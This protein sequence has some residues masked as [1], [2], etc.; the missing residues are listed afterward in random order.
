MSRTYKTDPHWVRSS[1]HPHRHI[2]H[3]WYCENHP[4]PLWVK[5]GDTH[6]CDIDEADTHRGDWKHCHWE[7]P[8]Y[9]Y[10]AYY[11]EKGPS[12]IDRRV[13]WNGPARAEERARLNESAKDYRAN[14][15]IDHVELDHQQHRNSVTWYLW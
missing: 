2:Y 11:R 4:A 15:D 8:S 14:G 7:L 10:P 5:Y 3:G 13:Y 6:P 12:K 9:V 1:R